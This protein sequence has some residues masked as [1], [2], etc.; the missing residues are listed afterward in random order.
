MYVRKK[1][2]K[3]YIRKSEA[4]VFGNKYIYIYIIA[5][6]CNFFCKK[7]PFFGGSFL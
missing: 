3:Y 4:A 6:F 5:N 2:V 1:V 7:E